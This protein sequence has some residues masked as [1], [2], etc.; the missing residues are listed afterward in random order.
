VN[1]AGLFTGIDLAG[2]S[3]GE[4]AVTSF[5]GDLKTRL[6]EEGFKEGEGPNVPDPPPDDPE[7]SPEAIAAAKEAERQLFEDALYERLREARSSFARTFRIGEREDRK[8]AIKIAAARQYAKGG[9][10]DFE[11]MAMLHGSKSAPEAVLSPT[12]TEMFIG[13]RNALEKMDFGSNG[14]GSVNIENISISTASLNNNQDFNR[15]GE[16]LADAFRTAIQ[17]KGITVNTNKT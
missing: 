6:G 8:E 13:L 4:A 15:A 11:G 12:Q 3:F 14:G 7:D 17:R 5:I 9:V 16:T 1:A 2:I 10:V